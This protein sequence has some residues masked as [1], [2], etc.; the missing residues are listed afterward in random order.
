[1][2]KYHNMLLATAAAVALAASVGA[3]SAQQTSKPESRG[4]AP[5]AMQKSPHAAQKSPLAQRQTG[6]RPQSTAQARPGSSGQQKPSNTPATAQEQQRRNGMSAQRRPSG[7]PATAQQQPARANTNTAQRR[8][9]L[10]GLQGNASGTNVQLTARQRTDFRRTIIDARGAPKVGHVNFDV[11]VGTVVPRDQ[12]HAAPVP[13]AL[14][15]IEPRWR[16]FLYF[17]Y[18]DEIVVVNPHD[19]RIVA[20]L[21]V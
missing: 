9:G 2:R 5:H 16:G 1:M 10:N 19:M 17:V 21:M 4:A 12:V 13:E 14:V 3:A 20:V 7:A 6:A 18:T 15:R 8:S 11:T